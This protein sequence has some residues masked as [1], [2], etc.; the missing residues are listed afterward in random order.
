MADCIADAF[1]TF[2]VGQDDD[3]NAR[4]IDPKSEGAVLCSEQ[5]I[6]RVAK[7]LPSILRASGEAGR[8][9]R[10]CPEHQQDRCSYLLHTLFWI[11]V[12]SAYFFFALPWSV[13]CHGKSPV[14]DHL[15]CTLFTSGIHSGRPERSSS[16]MAWRVHD[17]PSGPERRLPR[18][19]QGRYLLYAITLVTLAH[20]PS[21]VSLPVRTS[22]PLQNWP[23]L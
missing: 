9:C 6:A 23:G 8:S 15:V 14:E 7:V 17:F 1:V 10:S 20:I 3:A 5:L 21:F 13:N 2:Q 22:E 11:S 12:R 16:R 19:S 4:E 18:L